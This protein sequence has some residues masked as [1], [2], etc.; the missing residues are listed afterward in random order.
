MAFLNRLGLILPTFGTPE[1]ND[2]LFLKTAQALSTTGSPVTI[3]LSGF[4]A[5]YTLKDYYVRVKIYS[6]GT[7]AGTITGIAVIVSDGTTFVLAGT[8]TPIAAAGG[9][10]LGI[11]A[12]VAGNPYVNTGATGANVG[13][14]DIIYPIL[15]DLAISQVQIY[16]TMSGA[17]A[18]ALMDVE[19]CGSN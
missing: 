2:T 10:L 12:G 4:T 11:V 8:T 18:T 19:V 5:P 6:G 13:G 3:L 15:T 9:G 1:S 7:A 14:I 16:V 17:T